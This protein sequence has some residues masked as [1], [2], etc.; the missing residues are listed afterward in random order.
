MAMID[1]VY[2]FFLSKSWQAWIIDLAVIV[3]QMWMLFEFIEA[4]EL[5]FTNEESEFIYKWKCPRNSE[6]CSNESDWDWKGWFL[7]GIM[8]VS[9]L[10]PDFVSGIK[11]LLLA[12]KQ[13]HDIY[14]NMRFFVGGSCLCLV[15][16][17]TVFATT[18]YNI[19]LAESNPDIVSLA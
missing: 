5:D 15:A 11:L 4:A 3:F 10:L 14:Q 12:G 9:H 7:F 1:S 16:V 19:A 8:M 17:I 6:V 13:R 18:V 2:S